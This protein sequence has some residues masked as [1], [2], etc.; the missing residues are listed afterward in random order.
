VFLFA[1]L[2]TITIHQILQVNVLSFAPEDSSRIIRHKRA[3][4]AAL[5]DMA[6]LLILLIL[7]ATKHKEPALL[8]ASAPFSLKIAQDFV[9]LAALSSNTLIPFFVDAWLAAM[10]KEENTLIIQQ[11]D[12]SGTAQLFQTPLQTTQPTPVCMPV[13]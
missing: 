1:Q 11:I 12:V 10:A 2:P 13:P 8:A 6:L 3:F 5:E 4:R 7:S 9:P